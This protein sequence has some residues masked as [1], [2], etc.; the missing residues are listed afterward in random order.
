MQARRGHGVANAM[1]S[2]FGVVTPF[3]SR[4]SVPLFIGFVQA[5]V[6]LSVAAGRLLGSM[7]P[8]GMAV[9]TGI[10]GYVPQDILVGAMGRDAVW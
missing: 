10:H 5:G 9:G 2:A 4:A 8:G 3:C 1:A 7:K 6:P